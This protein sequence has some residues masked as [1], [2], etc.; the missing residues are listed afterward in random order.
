MDPEGWTSLPDLL[1]SLQKRSA[2]RDVTLVDIELILGKFDK[3]RFE[4]DAK[5]ER[6]RAYYG[7]SVAQKIERTPAIPP[8]TLYHG[9][10]PA[11][12]PQILSE[13]LKP[14]GRQDV[15][16]STSLDTARKTGARK[17][18]QPVILLVDSKRVHESGVKFYQGNQD[19][20]L[21]EP[22]PPSYISVYKA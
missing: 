6:I 1:D 18:P 13:G 7:H 3:K 14:M 12:L 9:T 8:D 2:F 21:S 10:S 19:V 5:G 16:L 20:W 22:V 4:L 15:H 17:N 11:V